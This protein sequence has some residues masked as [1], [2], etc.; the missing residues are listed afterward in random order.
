MSGFGERFRKTG[1][2]IPKLLIE[3]EGKPII[4]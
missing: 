1:Y 4:A 3:V 2:T